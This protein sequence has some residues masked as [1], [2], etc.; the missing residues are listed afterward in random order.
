MLSNIWLML[1]EKNA[2]PHVA[3]KLSQKVVAEGY[4]GSPGVLQGTWKTSFQVL[5]SFVI[6]GAFTKKS[7]LPVSGIWIMTCL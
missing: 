7:Y 3:A 5:P 6:M 4:Y 2:I 1:G